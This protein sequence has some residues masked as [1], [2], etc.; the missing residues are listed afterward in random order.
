[1]DH[2]TSPILLERA[3]YLRKLAEFSDGS[4]SETL[5]E[6]PQYHTMLS[7]RSR[8]G[9]VEQHADFADVFYVLDGRGALI[10]GGT[11]VGANDIGPGE[12]RGV[13]IEGGSRQELRPGDVANVP[14]GLPHQ[15]I[16]PSDRGLTCFV[17]KIR[18][19]QGKELIQM[20]AVSSPGPEKK[21]TFLLTLRG[22]QTV[23]EIL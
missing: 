20:F 5:H 8:D 12:V 10:T 22:I 6:Y 15:M 11:I 4:A 1:M 13:S 3:A 17:I 19:N 23:E 18:E 16:V 9:L 2:W 7:F 21:A 14:A